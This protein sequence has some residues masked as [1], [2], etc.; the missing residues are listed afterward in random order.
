MEKSDTGQSSSNR[1]FIKAL[2]LAAVLHAPLVLG[3]RVDEVWSQ[4]EDLAHMVKENA[5]GAVE[6]RSEEKEA[7]VNK[8]REDLKQGVPIDLGAFNL[9]TEYLEGR[10]NMDRVKQ[11]ADILDAIEKELRSF[12]EGNGVLDVLQKAK[13]GGPHGVMSH[14]YLSSALIEKEGNCHASQKFYSSLIHRLYPELKMVYQVVKR[15][16]VPHTRALVEVDGRWHSMDDAEDVRV[17]MSEQD[18]E[19][20]VL[21]EKYDEIKNYVG[22]RAE[23]E[24]VG[25]RLKEETYTKIAFSDD[26]LSNPLPDGVGMGDIKDIGRKNSARAGAGFGQGVVGTPVNAAQGGEPSEQTSFANGLA[27]DPIEIEIYTEDVIQGNRMWSSFVLSRWGVIGSGE[28]NVVKMNIQRVIPGL[29]D[30]CS[31]ALIPLAKEGVEQTH[32]YC[33]LDELS[34]LLSCNTSVATE[35]TL[36]IFTPDKIRAVV[37]E[38]QIKAICNNPSDDAAFEKAKPNML[39]S[40]FGIADL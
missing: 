16:G 32:K 24:F 31:E 28:N 1:R 29:S 18:L 9:Q 38:E 8:L 17:P 4:K 2:G 35:D 27:R 36:N 15:N 25:A 20:T 34:G 40:V 30:A 12:K 37:S 3:D 14:S 7:Y 19:S 26:F 13:D 6:T 5:K 22:E 39:F 10:S 21:Y 23:G 11:S 33:K